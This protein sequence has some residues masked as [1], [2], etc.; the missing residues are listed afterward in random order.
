MPGLL[1]EPNA[2]RVQT[3]QP[4]P[5]APAFGPGVPLAASSETDGNV[6]P[7]E[8]KQYDQIVNNAYQVIYDDKSMDAILGNVKA[9]TPSRVPRPRSPRL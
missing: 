1:N 4:A 3:E 5:A 2:A 8:Q 9:A 6:S 7:E